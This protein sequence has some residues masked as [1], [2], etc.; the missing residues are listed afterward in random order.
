[1]LAK[2]AAGIKRSRLRKYT[3]VLWIG[4]ARLFLVHAEIF[5]ALFLQLINSVECFLRVVLLVDF[6]R[7]LQFS[8]SLA[9]FDHLLF[10]LLPVR[11]LVRLLARA[12]RAQ[13]VRLVDPSFDLR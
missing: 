4:T 3:N 10:V 6:D 13:L 1:M 11:R 2:N 9:E 8:D 12:L 7:H 5:V